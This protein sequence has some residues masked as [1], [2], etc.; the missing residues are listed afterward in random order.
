MSS[1]YPPEAEGLTHDPGALRIRE[2]NDAFRADG[3]TH[4]GL[5][6]V[7]LTRGL[8]ALGDSFVQRAIQAVR[9]FES[10]TPEND[11]WGEHDFGSFDLDGETIFW[12]IDYYAPDL[13]SGSED[14]A[15]P[16]RTR[17]VMTVM[18]AEEY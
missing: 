17:R 2:L 3:F 8:T 7:F 9:A 6:Q 5:G 4:P 10:F 1:P 14:P 18:L 15:D 11:P 12:K 16:A 13:E